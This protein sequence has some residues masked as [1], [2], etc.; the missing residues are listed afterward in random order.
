MLLVTM[1]QQ[2]KQLL[3]FVE[4][5]LAQLLFQQLAQLQF[6]V[7]IIVRVQNDGLDHKK[8]NLGKSLGTFR[9]IWWQKIQIW[10]LFFSD[11][12]APFIVNIVTDATADAIA[13]TAAAPARGVCL[14]YRQIP[15][16]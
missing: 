12:T 14:E 8:S 15:C 3:D 11:C 1:V 2:P 6:V 16:T 4:Y 10:Y 9:F 13:A 5:F 7:S